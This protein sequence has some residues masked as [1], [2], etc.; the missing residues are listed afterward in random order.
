MDPV[1]GPVCGV[2]LITLGVLMHYVK[3]RVASGS[4]HRN[5]VI[6][7]RTKAT[8]SSDNAWSAGHAAAAPMLTVTYLTAYALGSITLAI[9]LVFAVSD[10]ENPAVIVIP[11]SGIGAVLVL[12]SVA[13]AKA[14]AAA[15]TAERTQG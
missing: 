7:I 3:D 11:L 1:A 12:L 5:S 14:D 13:A 4:I 15:R 9:S 2:G 6:G 10:V 8:M